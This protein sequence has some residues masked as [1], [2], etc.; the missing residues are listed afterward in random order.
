MQVK[1][2]V[3]G[4]GSASKEEVAKMLGLTLKIP[5][6][7]WIDDVTDALAVA[8][9]GVVCEPVRRKMEGKTP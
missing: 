3:A 1:Q 8:F 5:T 4:Y 6:D 2:T 9:T 7:L